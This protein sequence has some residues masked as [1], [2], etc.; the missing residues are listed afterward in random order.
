M[1]LQIMLLK[2]EDVSID[3]KSGVSLIDDNSS[4]VFHEDVNGITH[5]Y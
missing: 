4:Q 5:N 1:D 2:I 3:D